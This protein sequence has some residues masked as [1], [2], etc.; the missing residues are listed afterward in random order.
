MPWTETLS[1][2]FAERGKLSLPL[3]VNIVNSRSERIHLVAVVR[4][5]LLAVLA[6]YG[7][8]AGSTYLFSSYGFFITKEQITLLLI[9]LAVVVFYNLV[10]HV[11]N[12]TLAEYRFSRHLLIL[13]DLLS[14]TVLIHCSGGAT[15]WFWPVYLIVTLEAAY[16]LDIQRDVWMI[17]GAGGLSYCFLLLAENVNI[18]SPVKMPFVDT[19]LHHD[20]L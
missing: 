13:L 16:L 19:A 9:T 18:I 17:G 20:T 2:R 5:V 1:R 10:S 11:K 6:S 15:S 7:A 4:W 3:E 8:L 14:I 12:R